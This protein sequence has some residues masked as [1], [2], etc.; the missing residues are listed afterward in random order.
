MFMIS[1]LPVACLMMLSLGIS[2]LLQLR[3]IL[4]KKSTHA[5]LKIS[6]RGEKVSSILPVACLLLLSMEIDSHLQLINT[7]ENPTHAMLEISECRHES[8]E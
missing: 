1:I 4:L 6:F 5:M 3:N 8:P 2:N 7:A